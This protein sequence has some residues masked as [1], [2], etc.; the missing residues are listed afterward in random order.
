MNVGDFAEL[1]RDM[2]QATRQIADLPIDYPFTDGQ[3]IDLDEVRS[4]ALRLAREAEAAIETFED[5]A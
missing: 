5:Q 1:V 4:F 3:L 2:K